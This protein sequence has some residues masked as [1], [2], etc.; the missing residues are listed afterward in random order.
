M[1]PERPRFSRH[2][3]AKSHLNA[4]LMTAQPDRLLDD[5]A[6]QEAR[7]DSSHAEASILAWA[8]PFVVFIAWLAIDKYLP[9][10]NPAKEFIRDG[11]LLA[12][13]L[14][15]SRGILSRVTAPYWLVYVGL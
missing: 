6:L 2:A 11:V 1:P 4:E 9:I 8:G 3:S 15:F 7:N 12:S 14:G 10:A 5:V 13:I